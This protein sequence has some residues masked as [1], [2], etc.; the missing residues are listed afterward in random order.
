MTLKGQKV[1]DYAVTHQPSM[2]L[3]HHRLEHIFTD[4]LIDGDDTVPE[5]MDWYLPRTVR[6]VSHLGALLIGL[7][8]IFSL[9]YLHFP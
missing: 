4:D 5:Y 2:A 8:S 6:F 9:L 3:W 1:L 7:V